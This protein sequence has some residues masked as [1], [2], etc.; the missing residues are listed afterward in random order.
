MTSRPSECTHLLA[1]QLVR[2]EKF[3]CALV[4]APFILTEKWATR[5]AAAKKLLRAFFF[6]FFFF[7]SRLYFFFF[8]YTYVLFSL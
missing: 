1:P 3:L 4:V 8:G 2:T 5:S 6:F 7:T